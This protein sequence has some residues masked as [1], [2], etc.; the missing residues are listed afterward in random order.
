ML[1]FVLFVTLVHFV[2][3]VQKDLVD[4]KDLVDQYSNYDFVDLWQIFVGFGY[5][6]L[7][8]LCNVVISMYDVY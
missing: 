5:K 2:Y 8:L 7:H 3:M 6:N 1:G 4:K